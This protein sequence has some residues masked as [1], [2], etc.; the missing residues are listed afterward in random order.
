MYSVSK[1]YSEDQR[2]S[3]WVLS[4]TDT[5]MPVLHPTLYMLSKSGNAQSTQEAELHAIKYFYTFWERKFG[6]S[7]CYYLI[8]N[9]YDLSE[10]I[11]ELETF[12]DWLCSKQHLDDIP[13][14]EAVHYLNTAPT[15]FKKTNAKRVQVVGRFFK[16]LI[17]HCVTTK[18]QDLSVKECSEIRQSYRDELA[19]YEKELKLLLKQ[20]GKGTGTYSIYNSVPDLM[21]RAIIVIST[22]S[23]PSRPNNRNPFKH[24]DVWMQQF[25]QLRNDLMIRLLFNYG[26]RRGELLLLDIDSVK[27]S[28]PTPAGEVK[29]LLA[30]TSLDDDYIDPRSYEPS[31]KTVYSHRVISLTKRDYKHLKGFINQYRSKIFDEDSD[32][33]KVLFTS[34]QHPFKPISVSRVKDIFNILD[35]TITKHYPDFRNTAIYE[36]LPRLSPKVARHTWAYELLKY[37][38][39]KEY[40]TAIKIAAHTGGEFISEKQIMENVVDSLKNLGGWSDYS[41]MPRNYGKRFFAEQA[42]Q[43]NINRNNEDAKKVKDELESIIETEKTEDIFDAF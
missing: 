13:F 7:F 31:I 24:K 34:S 20:G 43:K 28:A 30:V 3:T 25:I 27:M 1:V 18:Y 14:D 40:D 5:C 17:S 22:P 8:T 23:T 36:S 16:Y 26:L 19:E 42:N 21:R 29:Y 33:H 4:D 39:A 2:H 15:K 12:F 10:P 41:N 38:Y 32:N 11:S 35:E 9:K 37:N 6:H